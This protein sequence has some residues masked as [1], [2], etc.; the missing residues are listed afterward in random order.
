MLLFGNWAFADVIKLRIFRSDYPAFRVDPKSNGQSLLKESERD[1]RGR[2]REGMRAGG[3]G[4]PFAATAEGLQGP[5]EVGRSEE[6][7]SVRVF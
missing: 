5:P 7:S 3:R 1:W 6:G 2:L 4:W